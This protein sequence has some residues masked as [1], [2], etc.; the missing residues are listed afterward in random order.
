MRISMLIFNCFLH[1][2]IAIQF[3]DF[4]L[5]IN[6]DG[7]IFN[8][9]WRRVQCILRYF[10]M[11]SL[12][13][14]AL[15]D[16]L[17]DNL[18]VLTVKTYVKTIVLISIEAAVCNRIPSA[19]ISPVVLMIVRKELLQDV[20]DLLVFLIFEIAPVFIIIWRWIVICWLIRVFH[21][22]ACCFCTLKYSR[23][24][25]LAFKWWVIQI[26]FV[27]QNHRIQEVV[28]VAYNIAL[29]LNIIIPMVSVLM[30]NGIIHSLVV[31]LLN[32]TS[33]FNDYGFFFSSC[34]SILI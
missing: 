6:D 13:T 28:G 23:F 14:Y 3:S 16:I 24:W 1:T 34:I 7:D 10:T 31:M 30:V 29:D 18:I 32:S 25:K 2:S 22:A 27:V 8:K 17:I 26:I 33:F 4:N 20:F 15:M 9:E 5:V 21:F 19:S 12:W 11:I